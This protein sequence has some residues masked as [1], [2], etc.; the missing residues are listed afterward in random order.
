[1]DL[2]KPHF[3]LWITGTIIL[4]LGLN[5][6]LDLVLN[7]HDTYFVVPSWECG[8]LFSSLYFLLG[9]GYWLVQQLKGRLIPSL[10]T[11]HLFLTIGS[12]AGYWIV[13]GINHLFYSYP[14]VIFTFDLMDRALLSIIAINLIIQPLYL[15]IMIAGIFK[16]KK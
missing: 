6:N 5:P 13:Y 9:F 14:E 11:L 10:T 15:I 4:L 12:F 16:T 3:Y 1:M 7:I 2:N 8:V